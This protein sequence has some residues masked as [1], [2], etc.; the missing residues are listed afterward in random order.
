MI[1]YDV[2]NRQSFLITST[3]IEE[4]YTKRGSDVIIVLVLLASDDAGVSESSGLAADLDPLLEE[5]LQLG[6]LH[7]LVLHRF[8]T[9]DHK[10]RSLILPLGPCN[11]SLTQL[12]CNSTSSTNNNQV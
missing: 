5:L 8:P 4:V 7:D 9:V 6:E 3:W 2:A 1:V 10:H 12:L 11:C